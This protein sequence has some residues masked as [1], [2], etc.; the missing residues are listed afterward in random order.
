M[1]EGRAEELL[2]QSSAESLVGRSTH[3][4]SHMWLLGHSG[5]GLP[6]PSSG[7]DNLE[8]GAAGMQSMTFN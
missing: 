4:S 3:E 8:L 5:E 1:G 2:W 6:E 7:A